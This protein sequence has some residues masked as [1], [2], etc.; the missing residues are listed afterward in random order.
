MSKY[1][2]KTHD[3]WRLEGLYCGKWSLECCAEDYA[4]AKRL[5]K[6]YRENCPGTMFRITR[7]RVPNE[8]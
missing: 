2:R 1:I 8:A 5:R 3:E 7:H 4:E 6:E